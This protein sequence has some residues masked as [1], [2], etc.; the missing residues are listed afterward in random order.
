MEDAQAIFQ[1]L[2]LYNASCLS[3]P[4]R[5]VSPSIAYQASTDYDALVEWALAS[6]VAGDGATAVGLPAPDEVAHDPTVCQTQTYLGHEA[7]WQAHLST[8]EGGLGLTSSCS[9][10]GA[11]YIGC[12]ALVLGCVV[13]APARGN[14]PSILERLP[15]RLMASAPF[16]ELKAVAIK[17]SQE[18]PNRGCSGQFVGS[19]GSGRGPSRD[20]DGNSTG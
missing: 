20:R 1:I 6:I 4:L 3:H 9:I 15:E 5:T 16:E 2:R 8:R 18:K 17:E 12:Y 7:L 14:L 10:K 11:A 19:P 13:S